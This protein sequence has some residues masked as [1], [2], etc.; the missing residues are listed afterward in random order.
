M[1]GFKFDKETR[2]RYEKLIEGKPIEKQIAYMEI[3]ERQKYNYYCDRTAGNW[4]WPEEADRKFNAEWDE[5]I[6]MLD[7]LKAKETVSA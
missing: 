4:D 3:A 2:E 7:E 5:I 1:A 6:T